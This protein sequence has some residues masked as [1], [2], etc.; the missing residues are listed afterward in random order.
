MTPGDEEA[1]RFL[2]L[3]KKELKAFLA[4]KD[5]QDVAFEI[6]CFHAQQSVEKSLK[7]VLFFRGVQFRR[8]H[9]LEELIALLSR[10][11]VNTPI[12]VDRIGR[13]NPFAV[14]LRYDDE[15]IPTISLKEVQTIAETL[16]VW[17]ENCVE[18]REN[19]TV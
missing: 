1:L 8:T 2:R 12:S 7:A 14:T 17:S 11:S 5:H 3:A 6:A 10:N 9:D 13:L 16:L 15:D 4:M 18:K 19:N